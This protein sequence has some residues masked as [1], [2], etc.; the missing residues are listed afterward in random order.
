MADGGHCRAL[1]SRRMWSEV[2]FRRIPLVA[3]VWRVD[4]RW[5]TWKAVRPMVL[6]IWPLLKI[7]ISRLHSHR[8]R[9]NMGRWEGSGIGT[10]VAQ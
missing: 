1:N 4:S 5:E 7:Q 10:S 8:C 2:C 3:T 6:K 9:F